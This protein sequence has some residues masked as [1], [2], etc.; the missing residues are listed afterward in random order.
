MRLFKLLAILLLVAMPVRAEMPEGHDDPAFQAAT[1]AWLDGD[2]TSLTALARLA[3][4]G[5]LAAHIL[6][7]RIEATYSFRKYT[8]KLAAGERD[9]LLASSKLAAAFDATSDPEGDWVE[10]FERLLLL[11]ENGAALDMAFRLYAHGKRE[12]A[13]REAL[14]RLIPA[15]TDDPHLM[16]V[17]WA[18]AHTVEGP[19]SMQLRE[20]AALSLRPRSDKR[21]GSEQADAGPGASTSDRR[22]PR[23]SHDPWQSLSP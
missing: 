9:R 17:A 13:Y 3:Q 7:A 20:Q 16:Q 12:P 10:A 4:D 18:A 14:I 6:L 22:V 5:N 1:Q 21:R 8:D 19:T 23:R 15:N 11:G 2:N